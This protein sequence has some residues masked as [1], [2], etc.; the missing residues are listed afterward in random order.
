[1]PSDIAEEIALD[2]QDRG[3]IPPRVFTTRG[4]LNPSEANIDRGRQN[5]FATSARPEE[6]EEGATGGTGTG[7]NTNNNNTGNNTNNNQNNNNNNNDNAEGNGNQGMF[8]GNNTADK[9]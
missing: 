8:G 7:N 4:D 6:P 5:P 1:M 9:N 2:E 3:E